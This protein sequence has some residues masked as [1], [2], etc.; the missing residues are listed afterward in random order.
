MIT[1]KP[2]KKSWGWNVDLGLVSL[3][4]AQANQTHENICSSQMFLQTMIAGKPNKKF[5]GKKIDFSPVSLHTAQP[6]LTQVNIYS[7]LI[8][9]V[10]DDHTH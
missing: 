8:F 3:R 10:D 4:T 9:F 7:P 5:W 6:N 1:R 2:N